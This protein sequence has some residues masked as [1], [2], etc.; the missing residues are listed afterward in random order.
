MAVSK[1]V[2]GG[3][4]PS[5]ALHRQHLLLLLLTLPGRASGV[6]YSFR[7]ELSHWASLARVSDARG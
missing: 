2:E 5:C 4:K 6:S 3:S 1:A 7:K